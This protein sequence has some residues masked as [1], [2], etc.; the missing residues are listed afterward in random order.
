VSPAA[1][2]ENLAV[3]RRR[4]SAAGG[5]AAGVTVVGV[6]KG[7]GPAAVGAARQAGL[8]DVGE[9]YAAELE[10]KWQPGLR[11]HFLG[12]VQRNKVRRLGPLVDVWQGVDREAA[13]AEIARRWPGATVLVEVDLS[14]APGRQGCRFE[15]VGAL[16]GQSRAGGLDV[17]GLMAVGPAGPPGDARGGFR[18]LAAAARSLGLPEVSMGMSADLEVAVE[19]GST[20]VRIGTALFGPRP[21]RRPARR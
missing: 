16:V 15:D 9:N 7:F 8:A 20:M 19:E 2:A 3:V 18:R 13:V 21:A 11:W 14:G 1:V 10:A 5:D 17:R 12:A 6:T 4:I